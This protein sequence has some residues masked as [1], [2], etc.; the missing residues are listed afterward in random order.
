[1][2]NALR[3]QLES[4]EKAAWQIDHQQAMECRDLEDWLDYAM[5]VLDV[6]R[7]SEN[8]YREHL[9]DGKIPF[10][11]EDVEA[12]DELYR[13][14]HAPC[15][16]LLDEIERVERRG[17]QVDNAGNFRTACES[18]HVPGFDTQTLNRARQSLQDT[19]GHPLPR[20]LDELRN[21]PV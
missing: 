20:V 18:S 6:I 11:K 13:M 3:S 8:R 4:Y 21:P 10:R 9:A 7:K 5:S 15:A 17:Y 19:G 1:M 16:H 12:I 2:I 14:W